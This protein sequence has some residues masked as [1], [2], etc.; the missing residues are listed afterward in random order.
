[1]ENIL[2][3]CKTQKHKAMNSEVYYQPNLSDAEWNEHRDFNTTDVFR[4]FHNAKARFPNNEIGAYSGNDIVDKVFID[5]ITLTCNKCG[6]V[7]FYECEE[8]MYQGEM[9]GLDD[10]TNVCKKCLGTE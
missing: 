7:E 10:N 8:I 6:H 1:M 4:S 3:L 2:Y 9:F 5:D